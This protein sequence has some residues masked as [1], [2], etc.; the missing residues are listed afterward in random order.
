MKNEYRKYFPEIDGARVRGEPRVHA[1][2]GAGRRR[3]V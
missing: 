2:A 1:R 3:R